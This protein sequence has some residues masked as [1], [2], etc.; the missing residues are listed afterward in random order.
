MAGSLHD[1]VVR[2][3][4]DGE[5]V[6]LEAPRAVPVDIGDAIVAVEDVVAALG[7]A[8]S[9]R[10]AARSD[11]ALAFGADGRLLYFTGRNLFVLVVPPVELSPEV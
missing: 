2:D 11:A 1:V 7:A 4:G 6:R 5:G 9:I 8:G 10:A 3:V